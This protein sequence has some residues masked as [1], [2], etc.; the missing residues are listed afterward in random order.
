MS[1]PVYDFLA[2]KML[3]MTES[4][5]VAFGKAFALIEVARNEHDSAVAVARLNACAVMLRSSVV[6]NDEGLQRAVLA[7]FGIVGATD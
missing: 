2:S 7:E 4:R 3:G 6:M 5:A 1:D